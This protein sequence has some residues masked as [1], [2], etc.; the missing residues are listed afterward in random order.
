MPPIAHGG[1]VVNALIRW[2]ESKGGGYQHSSGEEY[3]TLLFALLTESKESRVA[4]FPV[5]TRQLHLW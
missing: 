2:L 5:S 3:N 1:V 4:A